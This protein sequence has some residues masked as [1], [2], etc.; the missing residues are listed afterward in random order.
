MDSFTWSRN[1]VEAR[2]NFQVEPAIFWLAWSFLAPMRPRSRRGQTANPRQ[3]P[4][5]KATG[6]SER[7]T[8]THSL[9]GRQAC[10]QGSLCWL[11]AGLFPQLRSGSR[12]CPVNLCENNTEQFFWH[13]R[14][15]QPCHY[16]LQN[17]NQ[18]TKVI[19]K[20]QL[21]WEKRI[22]KAQTS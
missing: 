20:T 22:S 4:G 15:L 2:K 12:T 21:V 7:Q 6:G 13:H 5:T 3:R 9:G 8:H 17:K 1:R 16:D 19:I 14:L 10:G 11:L 18:L